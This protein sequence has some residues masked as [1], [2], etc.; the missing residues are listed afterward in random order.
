VRVAF[1]FLNR[2]QLLSEK[3]VLLLCILG[4]K[5]KPFF[6]IW[7]RLNKFLGFLYP[8]CFVRKSRLQKADNFFVVCSNTKSNNKI[9]EFKQVKVS[10][11][12][13]KSNPLNQTCNFG[14][15]Q[16]SCQRRS[17]THQACS[18]WNAPCQPNSKAQF[19]WFSEF[20]V[21]SRCQTRSE[22]N[23]HKNAPFVTTKPAVIKIL[24][25]ISPTITKYTTRSNKLQTKT[26]TDQVWIDG[27][28]GKN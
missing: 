9:S 4:H 27:T 6:C 15:N 21:H 17:N 18:L 12:Q 25:Q 10:R 14:R 26:K 2:Q 22:T 28:E 13:R 5:L 8:K 19:W 24:A 3:L 20:S 1:S 23:E 7:E 11:R 16:H